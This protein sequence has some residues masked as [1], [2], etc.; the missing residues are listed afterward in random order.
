MRRTDRGRPALR[1]TRRTARIA[2]GEGG[3]CGR[4]HG[5]ED[6]AGGGEGQAFINL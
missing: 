6:G 5:D 1:S 4:G 2:E 3:G